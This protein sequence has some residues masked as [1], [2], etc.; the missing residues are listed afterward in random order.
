[1]DTLFVNDTGCVSR[2]S[3]G[4]SAAAENVDLHSPTTLAVGVSDCDTCGGAIDGGAGG[5]NDN[6]VCE[7]G[8]VCQQENAGDGRRCLCRV[9]YSGAK[10]QKEGEECYEGRKERKAQIGSPLT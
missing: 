9:G 1:M 3:I 6:S 8:G 4:G 5:D 10:C 2:L 7:N